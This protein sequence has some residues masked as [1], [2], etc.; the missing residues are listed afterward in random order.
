MEI[1]AEKCT[2]IENILQEKKTNIPSQRAREEESFKVEIFQ[3]LHKKN[4]KAQNNISFSYSTLIDCYAA[5]INQSDFIVEH[6][7]KLLDLKSNIIYD[8]Q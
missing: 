8:L 7:W 1:G 6:C 5:A 4:P 3:C 2:R